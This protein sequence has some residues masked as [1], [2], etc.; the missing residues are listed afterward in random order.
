VR[1]VVVALILAALL[2]GSLAPRS[3]AVAQEDVL[4]AV[5]IDFGDG[6]YFW[7]S[8]VLTDNRT[9]IQATERAADQLGLP[10]EV[11]WFSFGAFVADIGDRDPVYPL[12]W[13]FYG[14]NRT[15]L[16][17]Q[18]SP[19]GA[20]DVELANGDAIGWLLTVDDPGTFASPSPI[21]SPLS[22]TPSPA[23]RGGARNLGTSPSE[24]P[25]SA[26]A[27]ANL[28]WS[29]DTGAFE[30]GATVAVAY[31]AVF[32]AT[33]NGLVA[34]D[35][36]T[37]TLLWR[38]DDIA[39][40]SSPAVWDGRVYVGA[41]DGRLHAVEA[42]SG[43]EVWN[44]TLLEEPGFTGIASAPAVA[45]GR[46]YVGVLNESGGPGGLVA[47]DVYT[48]Q[49]VWR[50]ETA[51]VHWSSP[52]VYGGVVYVGVMGTAEEGGLTFGPPY[53]V[54]AVNASDGTEMW[55][56]PTPGPVASSPA[57]TA[58]GLFVTSRDGT[59]FA[60]RLNGAVAWSR[61]LE[62][63]TTSSPAVADDRVV[64]GSGVLGGPGALVAFDREGG[65]RWKA[66][67]DGPVQSSPT[68][69]DGKV[70]FSTNEATG[71]VYALRLTDGAVVWSFIPEPTDFLLASPVV[72]NGGV[73]V[74]SDNGRVYALRG[75]VP[76]PL[77]VRV[78]V[79]EE[80]IV[81][82]TAA[83]VTVEVTSTAAL[84]TNVQVQVVPP[85]G[86]CVQ[87]LAADPPACAEGRVTLAVTEIPFGE[88][89]PFAFRLGA[90]ASLVGTNVVV[91]VRVAWSDAD[92]TPG[93]DVTAEGTVAVLAPPEAVSVVWI[94][95]AAIG[96]A[97]LA[98]LWLVKRK[99]GDRG[100][101]EGL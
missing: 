79:A 44:V 49:V 27:N 34:L 59:L 94:G 26:D 3:P 45:E 96:A 29:Y 30:I 22:P 101:P 67:V 21:P 40:M 76:R 70:V 87:V 92:G 17:W 1:S 86:T 57:V 91:Q 37:G 69:A 77:D 100:P 80:A 39:G 81:A 95:F 4:V 75:E 71:R 56:F 42:A 68:V 15:T 9:A 18:L 25:N 63:G 11:T 58:D 5:L 46:L 12:Y 85:R 78:A 23:F 62:G 43:R 83:N 7:T 33:W 74:A 16:A 66:A 88:T 65:L 20:S 28:V 10:I 8:V 2:L 50:Y 61:Q 47:L 51:S 99:R 38:R 52:G 24:M 84:L 35:E 82:G 41:R 48:G 13:H 97:A 98:A 60:L 36:S 32:A 64:V 6:L 93:G 72:A 54:A 73:F 89:F 31:G 53:G 19:L 14:W 55:F 90:D